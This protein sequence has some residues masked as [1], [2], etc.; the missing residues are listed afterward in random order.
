MLE[1]WNKALDK[2]ENTNI[3]TIFVD[4]S[5]TFD[6]INDNLLLHKL[7]AYGF[8]EQALSP[9]CSYLKSR[10]QRA[11]INN[12]VSKFKVVKTGIPQSSI[13]GPLFFYLFITDLFLFLLFSTLK[14]HSHIPK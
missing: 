7:R 9:M 1:K 6:S 4:L 11:Q 12:K 8:S 3:S 5:K 10:K 2:E 14:L 13:D